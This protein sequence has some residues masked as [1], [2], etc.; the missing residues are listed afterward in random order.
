MGRPGAEMRA[1]EREAKG[2]QRGLEDTAV[3]ERRRW[4]GQQG[5]EIRK[6]QVYG[7]RRLTNHAARSA[8]SSP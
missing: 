4:T 3:K 8:E 2:G 5:A 6:G 1:S 7:T